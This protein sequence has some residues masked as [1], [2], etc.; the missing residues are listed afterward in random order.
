M[1]NKVSDNSHESNFITFRKRDILN[2]IFSKHFSKDLYHIYMEFK[3]QKQNG[4]CAHVQSNTLHIYLKKKKMN[5][6]N[7]KMFSNVPQY[8]SF[9]SPD[10]FFT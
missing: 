10:L 9:H 8:A 3:G 7:L 5:S 1:Y 4:G 2:E 6:N